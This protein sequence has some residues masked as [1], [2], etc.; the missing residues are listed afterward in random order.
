[1]MT[2]HAPRWSLR[3]AARLV[4]VAL[5]AAALSVVAPGMA[6]ADTAPAP[7]VPPTVTAD[8]LPTWQVNGVVWSQAV[9]GTTVYV[10]GKFASAR[11]P[12]VAVGGAGEIAVNNLFAYD[13]R[14]GN[15]VTN[16]ASHSLNAQGRVIHAS[17]DGTRLYVGGDF[18]AVDGQP[19]GHIAAFDVATGDLV[20]GFAPM[21]DGTVEAI[22]TQGIWVYAGGG[23]FH[24]GADYRQRLAAVAAR[25]GGLNWSWMPTASTSDVRA[26]LISPD[27]TKVIIGGSF[28]TLTGVTANGMGAVDVNDGTVLPWAA[29][30]VIKDYDNG[31]ITSLSTDGTSIYGSGYA[32]GSGGTFEGSFSVN[33][34][35]GTINWVADC[36]GD[37]YSVVPHQGVVYSVGHSHDCT[38]IGGFP[39]TSPRVRWQRALAMTATPTQTIT[40]ADV[41][42]WNFVGQQ[43]PSVLHWYPGLEDGTAS[44]QNQAAWSVTASGDYV[45]MAGEFPLVNNSYQQGLTR[46]AVRAVAPN[47]ARPRFDVVPAK[48]VPTQATAVRPGVVRLTYG[49]AWDRDNETLTYDVFRDGT[50]LLGTSTLK[51]NFWTVPTVGY[52][53]TNVP[54]GPH[55]YQVRVTDPL[56]NTNWTTVSNSVTASTSTTAYGGAV[57]ADNPT[58]YWRLGEPAGPNAADYTGAGYDATAAAGVTF[59]AAG[60]S[61]DGD[62]AVTLTGTSTGI[63]PS[64]QA[65]T[66]PDTF[67]LEAWFKTTTTTGGKL[68]GYGDKT[69]GS[70]T[71][72]DRQVYMDNAGRLAFGATSL[73]TKKSVI[74]TASFNDGAWHQVVATLGSQGQR[75]FVDGVLVGRDVTVTSAA[76][77]LVGQWVLGGDTVSGWANAPSSKFFKGSLDEVAV[78]PG[79]LSLAR[80]RAHLTTAGKTVSLPPVPA[81]SYGSAVM[82]DGPSQYW[83]LA[84]KS[85]TTATDSSGAGERGTYSGTTS[86]NVSGAVSGD[87]AIGF[88]GSN[89]TVAN[90]FNSYGSASFSAEVWFNTTATKGGKLLGFGDRQSGT[91]TTVERN[92][93]MTNTGQLRF[94]T[95]GGAAVLDSPLTYRNG[96]WHQAVVTQGDD[97]M[98]MYVDGSL[99]ASN[100]ASTR[101]VFAGYWRVGGDR[102][103]SGSTSNYL[104]GN[105]DEF[106]VYPKVLG[107][108]EVRNHYRASG[109]TLPNLPPTAAMTSSVVARTASFDGSG[110][111]DPDGAI[112]SYAWD[113]GD[114]STGT[115][116]APQH[117]YTNPGTFVVRLTVTDGT[118]ST[119]SATGS[120]TI[121]N[122]LP[123]ASFTVT[124]S[125]RVAT[126]NASA[127]S[128]PD[129][130]IASYAWNFGDGSTG[131]G[132]TTSHTYAAAG[133]YTITL[134]VTDND[135]GVATTTRV[136]H[137]TDNVAPSASFSAAV[138]GSSVAVDGS[139]SADADGQVASYAWTYGDGSTGTGVT[140][141]HTYASPG[142]YTITLTVSDDD[143]ATAQAVKDVTILAANQLPTASFS[144]SNTADL[145]AAVDATA[146]SDPDGSITGYAWNFGDGLTGTGV[147]ATHAY[148]APGT[149]TVTLTVTDNRGG[150]DTTNRSLAVAGPF[151]L[152]SFGRTTASGWG[153]AQ[154]GG[155]WTLQGAL[156]TASVSGGVGTL[157]SAA[158]GG[159]SAVQLASVASTDTDLQLSFSLD[160]LANGGGQ[161]VYVTGRGTFS[162]AYR[163]KIQVTSTGAVVAALTKVVANTETTITSKVVTGLTVAPGSRVNVRM[164]VWGA[165]TTS[166]RV[167]VWAAGTTEPTDWLTTATDTTAA[168]QQPAGVGVRTYLSGTATNAPIVVSID[169]LVAR[170]TGN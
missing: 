91:S 104:S 1:M 66:A 115:G 93:S 75:L 117:T 48:V 11:P 45:A 40:R 102:V 56:G 82:Q 59:G 146:S 10:T 23:F 123:A 140:D 70:S 37:T 44:G 52:T 111:S 79:E 106:A 144:A 134:T 63:L 74:S 88:N 22:A 69:N 86:Y 76:P 60:A 38:V 41:Y 130:Q 132:A 19:R 51:T 158:A 99:V 101:T 12:G 77:G 145:T 18:T 97:G 94:A 120:V 58:A 17:A 112:A 133:D 154:V 13:I 138:T 95:N 114:G 128:D 166:M 89:T 64:N 143:G 113:F 5:V 105:L 147:T 27:G 109:R 163:T 131:T 148:A 149:Y 103:W 129:G 100:T 165:P 122:A 71:V 30:S 25:D 137:A 20:A 81:D 73:G 68:I 150:T 87:S 153:S 141:T 78:Y 161:Y 83:R 162:D 118:G 31:G 108:T 65:G 167:K 4:V 170:V 72:T 127:S 159:G 84:E 142:T 8:A 39:D 3:T 164:Q 119:A 124:T 136:A 49:T 34:D 156:S 151:A 169:D 26:M 7:G 67:S 98:R 80:V 139:A 157:R 28:L 47:K 29:S 110:S 6:S 135:G 125:K 92:L 160:K 33:P 62:T 96:V 152:D 57:L 107:L 14:T 43:A 54:A 50:T 55:T 24:V 53:D 116:V 35:G 46:F 2:L 168:L 36:L 15:P 9:I 85:G 42:G 121:Q 90:T 155:A 61:G 126:M 32:F 16:F 21:M